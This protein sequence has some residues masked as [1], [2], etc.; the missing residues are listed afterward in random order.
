MRYRNI[1]GARANF[2]NGKKTKGEIG[3]NAPTKLMPVK[4]VTLNPWGILKSHVV[5]DQFQT[6]RCGLS[7]FL[8]ARRRSGEVGSDK[9]RAGRNTPDIDAVHIERGWREHHHHCMIYLLYKVSIHT[10]P[11]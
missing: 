1:N 6:D 2:R 5:V 9:I 7:Q 4:S 8:I 11:P 3:R 10:Y